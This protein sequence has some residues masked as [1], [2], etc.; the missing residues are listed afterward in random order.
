MRIFIFFT[1]AIFTASVECAF[2]HHDL[3]AVY[4]QGS[5]HEETGLR[6]NKIID[7]CFGKDNFFKCAIRADNDPKNINAARPAS[8]SYTDNQDGDDFLAVDLAIKTQHDVGF[9]FAAFKTQWNRNDQL[10]K[11]QDNFSVGGGLQFEFDN[12]E[13]AFDSFIESDRTRTPTVWSVYLDAD[14]LY[15]K[16]GIFAPTDAP[17]CVATPEDPA[18]EK[19]FLNSIRTSVTASPYTDL[20][21]RFE[22]LYFILQ[23]TVRLFSDTALNNSVELLDGEAAE[24]SVTGGAARIDLAASPSVFRNR[25]ELSTSAQ[26]I[27]AFS[28]HARRESDFPN[29]SRLFEASISLALFGSYVGHEEANTLIPAVTIKYTDGSDSLKGRASQQNW[30]FSLTIKY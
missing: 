6:S 23:P 29:T 30:S 5:N 12:V 14:V 8:F 18:C 19:Q 4:T 3:L 20:L 16:K 13:S 15:N 25:I 22:P 7:E 24:G 1:A 11:Q 28:R 10:R 27:E 2:A 26:I 17:A 21:E 9:G